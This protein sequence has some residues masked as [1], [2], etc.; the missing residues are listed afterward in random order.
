MNRKRQLLAVMRLEL[1]R[2]FSAWRGLWLLF[3]AFAPAVVPLC[4]MGVAMEIPLDQ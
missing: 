3:L 2:S 1:A 4:A